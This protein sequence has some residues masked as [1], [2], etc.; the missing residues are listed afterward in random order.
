VFPA[1]HPKT[2]SCIFTLTLPPDSTFTPELKKAID[3]F[4][5]DNKVVLFIKGTKDFPSC[6]FSQTVSGE[7]RRGGVCASSPQPIHLS[8]HSQKSS[9][10]FS[11]SQTV[12]IFRT[13]NVPFETVNVL[14]DD[15][16]RNGMKAYSG[17]PTFPQVRREK[18][19]HPRSV[20]SLFFLI[21]FLFSISSTSSSLDL[22]QRRAGGRRRYRHPA[23][24][25]RRAG[26]DGGDRVRRVK[27]EK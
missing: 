4:I 22:P 2:P 13:M 15:K 18:K 3:T 16:L 9:F 10:F 14:E 5:A 7:G 12:N 19:H 24:P 25:V 21:H 6:G 26:G 27:N 23:V 20:H 1:K 11:L 8:I 17:W